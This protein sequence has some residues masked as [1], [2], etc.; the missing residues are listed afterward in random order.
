[1]RRASQYIDRD[2]EPAGGPLLRLRDGTLARLLRGEPAEPDGGEAG[3]AWRRRHAERERQVTE[4][5]LA[6]VP[7]TAQGRDWLAAHPYVRAHLACHAAEVGGDLLAGLLA[8]LDFLAVTD[9]AGVGP[10]LTFPAAELREV[11]R[12]Y[13]RARSLLGADPHANAAYLAEASRAV[14]GAQGGG[15]RIRPLYTT[16]LASVPHDDSLLVLT[17]GAGSV[18]GIAVATSPDGRLLMAAACEDG[19]VRIVDLMAAEQLGEPLAGHEGWVS[20]VAFGTLK[21]EGE[22]GAGRLVLA[23]CGLDMTVRVWDPVA[24]TALGGPIT[25]HTEPVISVELAAAPGGGLL[26]ASGGEDSTVRL[27]DPLTGQPLGEP[28]TAHTNQVNQLAFGTTPDGRLLLASTGGTPDGTIRLWDP[29]ARTPVGEPLTGHSLSV[30]AVSFGTAPDGRLL[31]ASGGGRQDKTVRLWDP[32]TGKPVGEPLGHDGA[33][34]TVEFAPAPGGGRLLVSASTDTTIRLWDLAD[35]A[36][37]GEPLAGHTGGGVEVAAVTVPDGRLLLVSG[38]E[39]ATVRLWDPTTT[40]GGRTRGDNARWVDAVAFGTGSDG[41]LLLASAG[42]DEVVRLWDA[43]SGK[44]ACEPVPAQCGSVLSVA[45]GTAPSGGLLLAWAGDDK[46][47]RVWDLSAGALVGQPLAGHTDWVR[48]VTFGTGLDQR[49]LLAS[50]GDDKV[51]RVWDPLTG[52]PIGRPRPG[53]TGWIDKVAFGTVTGGGEVGGGRPLLATASGDHT[54]RVW[55]PASEAEV[56]GPLTGHD[57]P[58]HTVAF[59]ASGRG[60]VVLASGSEDKTV[61]VWDPLTGRPLGGP[62]VGHTGWVRSVAFGQWPDGGLLLA[63]GG[64]DKT[65]R[66]WDPVTHACLATLQR[67]SAVRALAMTGAL[68]AVGSDDGLSVIELDGRLAR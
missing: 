5:L 17:L 19:T 6:T 45:L 50:V 24:G 25:G 62:L 18:N 61:R 37:L 33:V 29:L 11:G 12:A 31:L 28:L 16:R 48:S 40:A 7:V 41:Q 55:D 59:S 1:L 53:H 14:T 44:P 46:K 64:G 26:L 60:A 22:A 51:L 32:L 9:P 57:G 21:G 15:G 8:D 2:D 20:E 30:V 66:V 65:V 13:W 54:V 27:W 47:V 58:V 63:S 4:A 52:E 3:D 35:L 68:L 56:S 49:L 42:Q 67:R 34:D 38:S 43:A 23:S 39:D 36:P 10:L